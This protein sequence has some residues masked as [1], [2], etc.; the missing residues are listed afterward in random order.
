MLDAVHSALFI[1]D[2]NMSYKS[3]FVISKKREQELR[4]FG[5]LKSEESAKNMV[6]GLLIPYFW[7]RKN[8]VL[9]IRR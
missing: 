8:L 7:W 2:K 5:I 3:K 9:A 6:K 4:N 1:I